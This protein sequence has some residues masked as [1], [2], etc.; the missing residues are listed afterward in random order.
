M[1]PNAGQAFPALPNRRRAT[2]WPG[3]VSQLSRTCV[4]PFGAQ[5]GIGVTRV[6]AAVG[7]PPHRPKGC[8]PSV[9]LVL[10][11]PVT[12]HAPEGVPGKPPLFSRPCSGHYPGLHRGK[13]ET[14]GARRCRVSASRRR[15]SYL[16]CCPG[17]P[18]RAP[19][20][21]PSGWRWSSVSRPPEPGT[22]SLPGGSRAFARYRRTSVRTCVVA[23]PAR[24]STE[25][26][27]EL[28]KKLI[29]NGEPTHFVI[30]FVV[31]NHRRSD[32]R[33]ESFLPL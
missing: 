5:L 24:P 33:P 20:T 14:T 7:V 12:S 31:L 8:H 6:G 9:V 28:Q 15:W 29:R 30:D 32:V 27:T 22:V 1:G 23:K 26:T 3:A 18:D 2:P 16:G 4:L 25:K 13:V 11:S 17:Y 10:S 19:E 21:A